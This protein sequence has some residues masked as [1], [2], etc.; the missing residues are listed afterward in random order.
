MRA[1]HFLA[2]SQA[3]AALVVFVDAKSFHQP[4]FS[5]H[6]NDGETVL[7]VSDPRRHRRHSNRYVFDQTSCAHPQH[8]SKVRVNEA[9]HVLLSGQFDQRSR[10]FCARLSCIQ[11]LRAFRLFQLFGRIHIERI[12]AQLSRELL[13]VFGQ[14]WLNVQQEHFIL[15]QNDDRKEAEE[16]AGLGIV[17]LKCVAENVAAYCVAKEY[18]IPVLAGSQL[19]NE[20]YV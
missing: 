2:F 16:A 3:A 8:P 7:L 15:H 6:L 20:N 12:R 11:T 17:Y 5:V 1:E 18:Q 19:E 13:Q 14:K 10:R 9:E 4:S